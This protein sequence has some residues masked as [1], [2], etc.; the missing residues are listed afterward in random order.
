MKIIGITGGVGAGKTRILGYLK[1]KY[2][3]TICQADEIAKKLQKKGN[4]CYQQMVDYFG[5]DILNEKGEVDREVL[6]KI[7]FAD[8]EKLAALNAMVHPAVREEIEKKIKSEQRK[9]TSLFVLE[10]A[11]L[12]ESNYAKDCDEL[13]YVYVADE[14][15]KKRLVYARGYNHEKVERIISAQLPK[16]RFLEN[17]DRVI[18]N[19]GH[20]EE[21][22]EQ[23]DEAVRDLQRSNA[24]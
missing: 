21:T 3:A 4:Q 11:L 15:R 13:W 7:V 10:A 6:S 17:C 14:I 12:I 1:D 24:R 16:E 23:L 19:N 5:A 2:G 22:K 8:E 20:F 9:N 18:D